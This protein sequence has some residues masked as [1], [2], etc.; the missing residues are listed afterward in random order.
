MTT[1][2][3]STLIL[4]L[5]GTVVM[6]P[7]LRAQ[8]R[9]FI[10]PTAPFSD[11]IAELGVAGYVQGWG[12]LVTS[13]RPA[14]EAERS[15]LEVGDVIVSARSALLTDLSNARPAPGLRDRGQS[16][17]QCRQRMGST[18]RTDAPPGRPCS[19]AGW[20]AFWGRVRTLEGPRFV[21]QGAK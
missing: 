9:G 12:F 11:K 2:K 10:G 4:A 6:A 3:K 17:G 15:G 7:V 8:D 16:H 20:C 18:R 13:V 1:M 5:L 21:S 19:P 14:S